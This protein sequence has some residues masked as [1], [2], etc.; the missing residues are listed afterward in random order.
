MRH[1]FIVGAGRSGTTLL[2]QLLG[3]HPSVG[4]TPEAPFVD[5]MLL[6]RHL[7]R[8]DFVRRRWVPSALKKSRTFALWGLDPS[9]VDFV[10]STS[11]TTSSLIDD[12]ASAYIGDK[13]VWID[14]T[15][16]NVLRMARVRRV[17]H[18]AVF[19]H[20]VR[21]GRDSILS[22]MYAGWSPNL[23]YASVNW[24]RR[25]LAGLRYELRHPDRVLRIRYE[26]LCAF[27]TASLQ[28]IESF[29]GLPTWDGWSNAESL[30]L[31]IR[32]PPSLFPHLHRRIGQPINARKWAKSASAR[33][34]DTIER[35]TLNTMHML[36]YEGTARSRL[37]AAKL[38]ETV[39]WFC[40]L[41][42]R[43]LRVP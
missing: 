4:V 17:F 34:V 39:R 37:H 26:D 2:G 13:D 10:A 11:S 41:V 1:C 12:L 14:K 7:L 3:L 25:V 15:P 43:R 38:L 27:P 21:D 18:D 23:T 5:W 24:E 20:V 9:L 40:R 35:L 19:L 42:G 33:D 30:A 6:R 22:N 31:L 8:F 36:G 32:S 29:L 16:A 28:L